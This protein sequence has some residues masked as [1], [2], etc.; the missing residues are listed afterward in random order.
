M[1]KALGY[2]AQAIS[3]FELTGSSLPITVIPSLASILKC[4][5]GHLFGEKEEAQVSS[6]LP[7]DLQ[8][9]GEN[10]KKGREKKGLSQEKA[11]AKLAISVRS[12]ESYEKGEAAILSSAFEKALSLYGLKVDEA[13]YKKEEAPAT[14]SKPK[15]NWKPYIIGATALA[16]ALSC[17]IPLGIHFGMNPSSVDSSSSAS[18]SSSRPNSSS[19]SSSASSSSSSSNSSSSSSEEPSLLPTSFNI[20][21]STNLDGVLV[22]G[23]FVL[24]LDVETT[25][26]LIQWSLEFNSSQITA[27]LSVTNE[28]QTTLTVSNIVPKNASI[29]VKVS[30]SDGKKIVSQD[31]YLSFVN[32]EGEMNSGRYPGLCDLFAAVNGAATFD[33][34]R[35]GSIDLYAKFISA[36][37]K[38]F[39]YDPSIY[40]INFDAP[41][42]VLTTRHV[43]EDDPYITYSV[44]TALPVGETIRFT[45]YIML[46]T[47]STATPGS[48]IS[49]GTV[50]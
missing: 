33:L 48:I 50:I 20:V 17:A 15:R 5:V 28:S 46:L 9:L 37:G 49:V 14:I 8:V 3:K 10:L 11:A 44:P 26:L 32:E 18:S 31:K 42:L 29:T 39:V 30:L 23:D 45:V 38:T 40:T 12:L 19:S 24:S 6:S 4:S 22:S 2:T 1:A 47:L 36:K 13:L 41:N 7:I 25:G 34:P 21:S 27:S 35:G 16:V 43:D